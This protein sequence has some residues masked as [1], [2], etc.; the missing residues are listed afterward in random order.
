MLGRIWQV[1]F[2]YAVFFVGAAAHDAA[3]APK[4]DRHSP[5]AA[6]ASGL[7]KCCCLCCR[8]MGHPRLASRP[9]ILVGAVR[10]CCEGSTCPGRH[11][12]MVIPTVD[13]C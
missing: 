6:A 12:T 2:R 8:H 5:D 4:Q 10:G 13:T 7:L 3:V 9:K 11:C 1:A